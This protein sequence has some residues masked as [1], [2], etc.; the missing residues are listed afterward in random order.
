MLTI[1]GNPRL[2]KVWFRVFLL[3]VFADCVLLCHCFDLWFALLLGG[4]GQYQRIGVLYYCFSSNHRTA[5]MTFFTVLI[6]FIFA[7][8]LL[9]SI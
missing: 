5:G 6:L 1:V 9:S 3:S 4:C 7:L 8:I 2:R